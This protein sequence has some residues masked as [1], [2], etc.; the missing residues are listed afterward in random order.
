VRLGSVPIPTPSGVTPSDPW[1][2]KWFVAARVPFLSASVL[3]ALAATA[4]AWRLESVL[5]GG[6]AALALAGV[7]LIHLGVN[8]ANDY[9]DHLSGADAANK[10]P[11]PFSGGSRVI[12][13][14][15]LPAWQILLAAGL[16]LVA[17]CGVGVYLWLATPG[18]AVLLIGLAGVALGWFYS[19]PPVHLAHRGLG[20][21]AVGLGFGVLP[22]MGVEWVQRGAISPQ[23]SW[24]G[25]PAGLLVA[26]ILVINEFPDA[27]ADASAG[28]RTLVVRLG[29]ARA[30]RLY[31][32]L[33]VGAYASVG[34]GILLGWMPPVAAI[35][36]LVAPLSWKATRVLRRHHGEVRALLPAM[37]ATIAQESIFLVLLA[38]AY[39]V[40]LGL[41]SG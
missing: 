10:V 15:V 23:V 30:V 12:Q 1:L 34:V 29:A 36:A 13:E 40:E 14:G 32:A 21:V 41:R 26:A 5:R 33:V 25:V 20:E 35:V 18:H 11:T 24:V 28:K 2:K 38:G 37:A 39:L 31:E 6:L 19:C 4:A 3:P 9:F 22:A 17:G 7:A 16:L 8:L 27:G